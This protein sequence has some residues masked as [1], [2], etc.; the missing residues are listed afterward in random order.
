MLRSRS[1]VIGII[2][3][4]ECIWGTLIR[5]DFMKR[6]DDYKEKNYEFWFSFAFS[7]LNL[8]VVAFLSGRTSPD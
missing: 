7:F 8:Q 4:K 2:V 5:V 1:R 6:S 3:G